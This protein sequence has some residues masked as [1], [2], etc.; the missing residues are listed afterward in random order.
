MMKRLLLSLM[1]LIVCAVV[2]AKVIK[3]TMTDG[4]VLVFTTSQLSSLDFDGLGRITVTTYDGQKIKG[5]VYGYSE[6]DIN[7]EETV[8]ETMDLPMIFGYGGVNFAQRDMQQ[9]NF[10]YPSKD[11]NGD[12]ITLSGRIVIPKNIVDGEANSE[13]IL[14]F[15]HYTIFDRNEAPTCGESYLEGFFMAC[16]VKLN[17]IVV[18]SDYYG[19][20]VTDRFQQ[21]Y[22][23]GT[24]NARASL[25]CL[26]AARRILD[27]MGVDYGPLT[28]NLG[29][30]SGGFD[31]LAT[32]KLRDLE[33]S[34]EIS[35]DKTFAGGSPTDIGKCYREY[36]RIDSTAYNAVLALLLVSTNETRGLGLELSDVFQEP[37]ASKIPEWVLSKNYSSWPVCDSIGREKKIHEILQPTYCDLN[38]PETKAILRIFDENSIAHDWI[39]DTTQRYYIFH[40]RDDNYVPVQSARGILSYLSCYGLKPSL[41]P[42]KTHLQTNFFMKKLDHL[43]G[44]LAYLAQSVAALKAWPLMYTDNELNPYYQ[45]LVSQ[46]IDLVAFMRQLDAMGFDCRTFIKNM[47]TA[48]SS[49]TGSDGSSGDIDILAIYAKL[50]EMGVD[51][52]EVIEI[53][54][55]SGYDVMKLIIDLIAYMTEEP[56]ANSAANVTAR[57]MQKIAQ[58]LT[59]VE[60]YE[61]EVR[62]WME[63]NGIK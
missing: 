42:G 30:S 20:G 58:P 48:I 12:D 17:Y 47:I 50:Q 39:P 19:F 9:I 60:T 10:V 32:Q 31:A 1:T 46:D 44:I 7:D 2:S 15:N 52:Q 37:I 55:D 53:C 43:T 18:E 38:A 35:F 61:K 62:Q 26:L 22:L 49:A 6:V 21:A 8:Y 14:L 28:F 51:P 41:I 59:P 23:Q 4:R 24:H 36:V 3:I 29:Y 25:D 5:I 34:D 11:P 63:A 33:Y 45:Q 54:N 16:P 57:L 13:G 40:A 27:G 56:Q